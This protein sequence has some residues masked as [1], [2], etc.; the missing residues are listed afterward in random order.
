MYIHSMT[1]S[2]EPSTQGSSGKHTNRSCKYK[3]WSW[4]Q[5]KE[6]LKSAWIGDQNEKQNGVPENENKNIAAWSNIKT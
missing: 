6:V 5:A 2:R 3:S 4:S 1:S